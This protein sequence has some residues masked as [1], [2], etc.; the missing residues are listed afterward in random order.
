MGGDEQIKLGR[1]S[2]AYRAM[3]EMAAVN[4]SAAQELPALQY[5]SVLSDKC[6]RQI[7]WRAAIMKFQPDVSSHRMQSVTA[8]LMAI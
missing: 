2:N 7:G 4:R 3:K 5:S 6:Q 1:N 8:S